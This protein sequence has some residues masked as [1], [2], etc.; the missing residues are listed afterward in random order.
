L[1]HREASRIRPSV[2][3][4]VESVRHR[5]PPHI[6]TA[7]LVP[8]F[9]HSS[10]R[11][12]QA[13]ATLGV[14]QIALL[15]KVYRA[16]KGA[17]PDSLEPLTDLVDRHLPM[18]PFSGK[19]FRYERRGA[20][21]IVYSIGPNLKDDGGTPRPPPPPPP[22][23]PPEHPPTH[24]PKEPPVIVIEEGTEPAPQPDDIVIECPW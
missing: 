12:D 8:V 22:E 23:H 15:L 13:S 19:P 6:L 1:P 4:E 14:D 2:E 3:D 17:Y 7:I 11:R 16:R 9:A 20:G 21:F 18:D 24:P 10:R 5:V